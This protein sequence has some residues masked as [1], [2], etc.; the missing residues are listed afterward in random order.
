[1]FAIAIDLADHRRKG[2]AALTGDLLKTVP[3]LIFNA[4][5]R[6][7]CMTTERFKTRD[8]ASPIANELAILY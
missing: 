2:H 8:T 1:M 4:D 6:F 7:A 5:T 3:E